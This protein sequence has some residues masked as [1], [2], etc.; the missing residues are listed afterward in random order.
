MFSYTSMQTLERSGKGETPWHTEE[1]IS[2]TAALIHS[3]LD[4][5]WF[6]F[7][8]ISRVI[9][10][11]PILTGSSTCLLS[12]M[13][14]LL[15]A[16][17]HLSKRLRSSTRSSEAPHKVPETSRSPPHGPF[18]LGPSSGVHIISPPAMPISATYYSLST[19]AIGIQVKLPT[20]LH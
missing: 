18:R 11:A 12:K 4:C 1:V 10:R 7:S 8:A 6:F 3:D 15:H 9:D 17:Q 19:G 16:R 2:I 14:V 5:P 13:P 20:T